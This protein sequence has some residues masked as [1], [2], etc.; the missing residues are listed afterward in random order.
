[1]GQNLDSLV[2]ELDSASYDPGVRLDQGVA[3][4]AA[5]LKEIRFLDDQRFWQFTP[6]HGGDFESTLSDWLSNAC[7]TPEHQR[8]L[9]RLVPELQFVDREDLLALYRTAFTQQVSPWLMDQ[10]DLDFS[11]EEGELSRRLRQ[12][13]KTT[14][15]FCPVTD[16]DIGQFHHVNR[17][18]AKRSR[19]QWL[20]LEE[21]GSV[22]SV[23][24]FLLQQSRSR[25][26][27]GGL[28]GLQQNLW[29]VS[30]SGS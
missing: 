1:M 18:A 25:C 6:T 10:E 17:I 4:C 21:F 27:S 23:R 7:L 5:I 8:S 30:D 22:E 11:L 2:T 9:L 20:T 24:R 12:A 26:S 28:R 15:P 3:L 19:P 16:S 13:V 29:V 14:C